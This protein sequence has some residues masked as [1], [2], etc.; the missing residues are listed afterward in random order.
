[1]MKMQS[2]A[3]AINYSEIS[4]PTR[5]D[6]NF[7][8]ASTSLNTPITRVKIGRKR[9]RKKEMTLFGSGARKDTT[10]LSFGVLDHLSS[11]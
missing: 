7:G 11:G 4:Q 9:K 8:C 3:D 1:M 2:N 6:G 5:V 10:D